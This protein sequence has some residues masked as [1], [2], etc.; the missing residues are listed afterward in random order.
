MQVR[1]MISPFVRLIVFQKSADDIWS[2]SIEAR[3]DGSALAVLMVLFVRFSA[4]SL[5]ALLAS[6][7]RAL[8]KS[9]M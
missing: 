2:S 7:S 6:F 9:L 5:E 3:C 4:K 8:H 1:A